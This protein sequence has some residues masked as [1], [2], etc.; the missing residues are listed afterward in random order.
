VGAAVALHAVLEILDAFLDVLASYIRQGVLVAAVAGVV[1]VVVVDVTGRARCIVVAIEQKTLCMIECRGF[2]T[3]LLMALQA[4]A[5]GLDMDA[6]LGGNV[7]GLT[8]V[9]R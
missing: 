9:L 7:T 6:R 5:S 4:V 3:F 2:P 1:L 8:A